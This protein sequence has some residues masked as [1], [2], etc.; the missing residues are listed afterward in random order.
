MGLNKYSVK[1]TI[2][3]REGVIVLGGGLCFFWRRLKLFQ[4]DNDFI[5]RGGLKILS[6]GV[7][8]VFSKGGKGVLRGFK[9]FHA[10]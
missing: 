7:I 9:V 2:F 3:F 8:E 10:D 1:L 6:G 5:R 4:R